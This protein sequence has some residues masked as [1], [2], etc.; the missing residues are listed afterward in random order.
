MKTI[1]KISN[2]IT[3]SL[4][5]L[6]MPSICLY[7]WFVLCVYNFRP[8]HNQKQPKSIPGISHII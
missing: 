4:G 1:T 7:S 3:T 2:R 5:S 6:M 8:S